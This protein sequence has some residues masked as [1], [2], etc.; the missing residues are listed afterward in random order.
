MSDDKLEIDPAALR[1]HA[2]T[3]QRLSARTVTALEAAAYIA[4]ADDGFGAIPRPLIKW[5]LEEGHNGTVQSLRV[6]ADQVGAVP[7]KLGAN[8]DSFEGKDNDLAR[9][10]QDFRDAVAPPPGAQ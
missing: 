10:L 3:V 8:A 6:L 9:R 4:N 1:Q 7:G 2:D 5:L